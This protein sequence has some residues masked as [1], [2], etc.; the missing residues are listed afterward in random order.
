V[1]VTVSQVVTHCPADTTERDELDA[2]ASDPCV[3][4]VTPPL[5][6]GPLV[7]PNPLFSS[8]PVA[9]VVNVT[10][11]AVDPVYVNVNV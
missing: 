6:A 8:V 2:A 10:A 7:M 3:N 5:V 11:P 4:T 1:F 9:V